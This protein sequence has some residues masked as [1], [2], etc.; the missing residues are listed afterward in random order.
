MSSA[1]QQGG[2]GVAAASALT[3]VIARRPALS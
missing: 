1:S 2:S 3:N